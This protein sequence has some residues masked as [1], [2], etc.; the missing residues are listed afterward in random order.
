MVNGFSDKV[1]DNTVVQIWSEKRQQEKGDSFS[2]EY[3][4]ELWDFTHTSLLKFWESR[5]GAHR[6]RVHHFAPLLEGFDLGTSRDEKEGRCLRIEYLWVGLLPQS[7]SV[8]GL[9]LS[10]RDSCDL[11]RSIHPNSP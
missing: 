4:S 8:T 1:E 6:K 7:T 2:E 11:R 5:P 10:S 9:D 3:I